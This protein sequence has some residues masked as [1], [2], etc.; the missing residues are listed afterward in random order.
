ML[1]NFTEHANLGRNTGYTL[2]QELID[3]YAQVYRVAIKAK[4][5]TS[6]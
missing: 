2:C 3:Q 5:R 4:E 1:N 6:A